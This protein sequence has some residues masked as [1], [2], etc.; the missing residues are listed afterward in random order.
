RRD[1]PFIAFNAAAIPEG[2]VEAEL[3]GHIKGAFTGAVSARMGRFEAALRGTLFVDEVASMSL[4]LQRKL[5]RALQQRQIER[6]GEPRPFKFDLRRMTATNT[7]LRKMVK[8]GSFREDLYYRLNV[9]PIAVPP[10]RT[11]RDDIALLASHFVTQSCRV[12][13]LDQ[14][15]LSQAAL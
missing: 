8:E 6:A 1:Q 3:F 5:L 11:R 10:L 12:N 2:L 13:R 4:A 15:T 9:V 14:R 7:D